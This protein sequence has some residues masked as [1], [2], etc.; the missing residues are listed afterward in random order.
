MYHKL[1]VPQLCE[2]LVSA[3]GTY[4]NMHIHYI[5]A[6]SNASHVKYF[7]LTVMTKNG[8]KPVA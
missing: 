2:M 5:D 6:G 8:W 7:L 3:T 1:R 4:V